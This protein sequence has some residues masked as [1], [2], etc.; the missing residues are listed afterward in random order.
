MA[1]VSY[2][3]PNVIQ[4]GQGQT[5]LKRLKVSLAKLSQTKCLWFE[6]LQTK[7]NHMHIDPRISTK[8]T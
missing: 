1:K 3:K 6:I 4:F 8:S 5:I 7:K 2:T